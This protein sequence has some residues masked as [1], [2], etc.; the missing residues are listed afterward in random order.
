VHSPAVC[1][2]DVAD[3][4]AAYISLPGSTTQR[5]PTASTHA[6]TTQWRAWRQRRQKTTTHTDDSNKDGDGDVTNNEDGCN[7]VIVG[8]SP[9][10]T[11][12]RP[13]RAGLRTLD[14]HIAQARIARITLRHDTH[15]VSA[16]ARFNTHTHNTD[17]GLLFLQAG[18]A[19][20][21]ACLGR[22]KRFTHFI[23]YR[24]TGSHRD[25]FCPTCERA[26]TRQGGW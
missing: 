6:T 13:S 5:T 4:L 1:A 26:A 18:S 20:G 24:D 15:V 22:A 12:K 9:I 8:G 21:P 11:P 3:A 23:V 16:L 19:V 2:P 17:P 7:T 10:L 14:W 25:Q